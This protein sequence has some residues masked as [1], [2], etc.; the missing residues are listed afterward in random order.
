MRNQLPDGAAA[1]GKKKQVVPRKKQAGKRD[2]S[3]GSSSAGPR[4]KTLNWFLQGLDGFSPITGGRLRRAVEQC[5]DLTPSPISEARAYLMEDDTLPDAEEYEDEECHVL[6]GWDFQDIEVSGRDTTPPQID[7]PDDLWKHIRDPSPAWDDPGN[8]YRLYY[9]S[10]SHAHMRFPPRSPSSPEQRL[11][12][13]EVRSQ[14]VDLPR[15]ATTLPQIGFPA[16]NDH[17]SS[18]AAANQANGIVPQ[19][20]SAME[21]IRR[22]FQ[23]W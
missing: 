8:E 2:S 22:R 12:P 3:P 20:R 6:S 11:S 5:L 19:A 23:L 16:E 18:G 10:P 15:E 13:S 21:S 17:S 9:G 1:K 7:D 4:D 14:P